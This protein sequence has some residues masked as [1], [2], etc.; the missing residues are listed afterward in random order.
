MKVSIA[1]IFTAL[2]ILIYSCQNQ[3]YQQGEILY[4]N[5]CASCHMEDG[6]GLKGNIPPL[7]GADYLKINPLSAACIINKGLEG[8]IVVNDTLYNQPMA[9]IPQLSEFEI[10]NV[11][12]YINHA[13][14][15]DFGLIK[16]QDVR[17]ELQNCD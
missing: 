3:P 12:N 6:S 4:N 10:T 14:G 7:A 8:E 11:M 5:F 17:K 13:W 15:N 1:W 16:L 9:G 2:L